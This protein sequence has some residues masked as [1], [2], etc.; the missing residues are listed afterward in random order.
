MKFLIFC[1]VVATILIMCAGCETPAPKKAPCC[2]HEVVPVGVG[3]QTGAHDF[4]LED[5]EVDN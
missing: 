2:E 5:K 4:F 3:V 1:G